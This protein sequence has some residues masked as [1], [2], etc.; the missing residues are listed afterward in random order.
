MPRRPTQA[1]RSSGFSWPRCSPCFF[2]RAGQAEGGPSIR[3]AVIENA[4]QAV[5][6]RG[7]GSEY[8]RSEGSLIGEI[9]IA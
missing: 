1:S 6:D 5:E 7:V 2:H 3:Q 4:E 9:S 8:A